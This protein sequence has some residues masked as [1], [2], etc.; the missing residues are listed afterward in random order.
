MIVRL[1]K[2]KKINKMLCLFFLFFAL[3]S[4][5]AAGVC[6]LAIDSAAGYTLCILA[7]IAG[8]FSLLYGVLWLIY[9]RMERIKELELRETLKGQ[10]AIDDPYRLDYREFILPKAALTKKAGTRVRSIVRWTGIAAFA[11]FVLI[12][13]IQ[14]ACGSL[15]SPLQLL[16]MFLFCVLIMIPGILIQFCLYLKYDQSV[17]SRILLFPGKLVIDNMTLTANEIREIRVSP[18]QIFN[19]NSPDVFREM[20]I[21][22]EEGRTKYRIDYRTGTA[23]NEQPFWEEYGQFIETLSEWGKKNNVPVTVSYMA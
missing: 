17:P 4:L 9:G 16:Y 19:R 13:V 5:I 18:S 14:L 2:G 21:L 11:V 1:Y 7:M 8:G 22:T 12:G 3:I 6:A 10:N 23:F 20:L 15:K